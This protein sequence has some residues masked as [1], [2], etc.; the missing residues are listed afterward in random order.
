MYNKPIRDF[1]TK[2]IS[3][4]REEVDLVPFNL[5]N[6]IYFKIIFGRFFLEPTTSTTFIGMLKLLI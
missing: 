4:L 2:D 6:E 1:Y 5:L 3:P